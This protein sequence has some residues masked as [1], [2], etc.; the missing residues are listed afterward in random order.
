LLVV[1]R[2]YNRVMENRYRKN[3]GAICSL[4]YHL[5]WCP[6]YRRPVLVDVVESRL[7]ALLTE[8]A[9]E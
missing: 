4:K 6:K 3:P 1:C 9:A 7:R 2:V 5:V 8:K